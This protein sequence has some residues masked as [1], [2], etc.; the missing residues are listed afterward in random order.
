MLLFQA[1]KARPV[2]V[3]Q[4][5]YDVI[6]LQRQ[7]YFGLPSLITQIKYVLWLD[8]LITQMI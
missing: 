8:C 5:S 4:A 6:A 7:G 3:G 2:L 1:A